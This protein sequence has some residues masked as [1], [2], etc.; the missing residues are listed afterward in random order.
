MARREE[1]IDEQWSLIKP[2]FDKTDIVRARGRPAHDAR[3][4]I[5]DVL[6]ILDKSINPYACLL[7][8]S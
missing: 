4:V 8:L 5:N 6:W 3:E 7:G 2:L 1:L